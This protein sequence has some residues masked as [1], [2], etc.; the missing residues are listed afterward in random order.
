MGALW[1][2]SESSLGALWE[3]VAVAGIVV[4]HA[5]TNGQN[6]TEQHD[7]CTDG[8]LLG[9]VHAIGLCEN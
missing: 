7:F 1:E 4:A 9:Q 3:L 5:G 8:F 6:V 2:L